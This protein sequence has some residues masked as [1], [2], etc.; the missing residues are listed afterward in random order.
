MS[1]PLVLFEVTDGVAVATLNDTERLNPMSA[2]LLDG[3]LAV[4][5]RVRAD[6]GVR[7]L[8][9]GARGRAFCVGA[10]LKDLRERAAG[11]PGGEGLAAYVGH[12]LMEA[13]GNP[14]ILQLHTL[15]VPV[16]SA[17]NGPAVGGGMGLALA[18]D[19]VIAARSAYFSL[20]FVPALGLVPDM[21]VLWRA[22]RSV[23]PERA[24][25]L[26]LTGRRLPAEE[27]AQWGLIWQCVDD[28]CLMDEAMALARQLAELPAH[29]IAESR[30]M[31]DAAARHTLPEQLTYE[32]QRQQALIDGDAFAEG[33]RAFTERR[34]PQFPRG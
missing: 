21:G 8:V 15:R 23:G 33:L 2:D 29:A 5:D 1:K 19:L 30:A 17:I 3:L 25:G 22:L 6:P 14:A 18:A 12:D 11:R 13:R 34:K 27:A 10:D 9:L 26:M 24:A 28:A 16:V 4:L 32:R 20:P 7:A 31:L